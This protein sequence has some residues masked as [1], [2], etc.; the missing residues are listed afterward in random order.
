MKMDFSNLFT[1]K[2]AFKLTIETVG[3]KAAALSV[4]F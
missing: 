1:E 4:L 2:A 3:L